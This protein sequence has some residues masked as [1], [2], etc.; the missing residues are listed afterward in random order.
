MTDRIIAI[1]DVHECAKALVTLF[2]AIQPTGLGDYIDRGPDSRGVV[3]QVIALG[4]LCTVVPLLG[5]HEE[6]VLAALAGGQSE[7]RYWMTFGGDGPCFLRLR[8]WSGISPR[9]PPGNYPR[10]APGVHQN[11]TSL[12]RQDHS[13]AHAPVG[14]GRGFPSCA[15]HGDTNSDTYSDIAP[16]F[17][18]YCFGAPYWARACNFA[19]STLDGDVG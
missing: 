13:L 19:Q 18:G 2:E 3:E 10:R 6:M 11:L 12:A 17:R 1:G 9:W 5:N 8:R 15:R 4:K 16:Q 7:V 14:R